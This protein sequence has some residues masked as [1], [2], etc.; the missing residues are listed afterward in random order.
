MTAGKVL[1]LLLFACVVSIAT[2]CKV[3]VIVVEGGEV[4]STGSGNCAAGTICIVEVTDTNFS[5]TFTVVPD[6]GWYFEKWNSGGG[7]L[8]AESTN[9]ACA[10][11]SEGA[12]GH[13]A[14][15]AL[16]A[17]PATFYM[18][19]IFKPIPDTVTV[20]GKEWLQP[21]DFTDY[22]Y[23]Q[24]NAVCPGGLCSGNLPGGTFDLTGYTWA[25][26]EEVS[27]LF[28][29]YGL[30]P[31]FTAPFQERFN[32][33]NV[34]AAIAQHFAVTAEE[35]YGDCPVTHL[36]VAGMVRD[37]AP[38][39]E[40]LYTPYFNYIDERIP[41]EPTDLYFSNT[42]YVRSTSARTDQYG[43]GVWFWTPAE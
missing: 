5:E 29:S 31:P 30:N 40:A 34:N 2:G 3:A 42:V 38:A 20:D 41:P 15:E 9:Q 7:F 37:P 19:P 11:S 17:S 27:A 1:R 25:S 12:A 36:F 8:C 6:P 24:V 18:M 10:V 4:H 21:A 33:P 14:W 28:N 16:I 32:D 26:I 39:G 23:E 13:P 35:C 22:T 43:T